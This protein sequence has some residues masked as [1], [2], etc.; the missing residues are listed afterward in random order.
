MISCEGHEDDGSD[1]EREA[2]DDIKIEA[3]DQERM[4]MLCNHCAEMLSR[5]YDSEEEAY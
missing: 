1:C 5:E 4:I 2:V 3:F